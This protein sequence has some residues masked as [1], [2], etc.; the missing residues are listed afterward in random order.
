M[1][2][3]KVT[4]P[5]VYFENAG[6]YFRL[7]NGTLLYAPAWKDG[8]IDEAGQCEV[9]WDRISPE[10]HLTCIVAATQVIQQ[11]AGK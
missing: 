2:F 6:G 5:W 1:Y 10:D 7:D 4:T 11:H 9:D 8:S 3:G